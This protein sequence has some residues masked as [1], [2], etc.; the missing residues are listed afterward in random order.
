MQHREQP[1]Q[2]K[3]CFSRARFEMKWQF[4]PVQMF[5]EI[6]VCHGSFSFV[7]PLGWTLLSFSFV[8]VRENRCVL[9]VGKGVVGT[10]EVGILCKWCATAGLHSK[11]GI[12]LDQFNKTE[13]FRC[14]LFMLKTIALV[15]NNVSIKCL[16]T[17]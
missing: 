1:V 12:E 15:V 8:S 6:R 9:G 2:M 13:I 14:F 17:I 7:Y 16:H 5:N 10:E 4:F 3:I 11:Q